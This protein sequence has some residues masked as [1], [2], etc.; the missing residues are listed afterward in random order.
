MALSSLVALAAAGCTVE[1][2]NNNAH[3]VTV[4]VRSAGGVPGAAGN[5]TLPGNGGRRSE[6]CKVNAPNSTWQTYFAVKGWDSCGFDACPPPLVNTGTCKHYPY[7]MGQGV[8]PSNGKWYGSVGF[9]WDG[10][11]QG[12]VGDMSKVGYGIGLQ[13]TAYGSKSVDDSCSPSGCNPDKPNYGKPNSGVEECDTD[14]PIVVTITP[15]ATVQGC[16][17]CSDCPQC[18]GKNCCGPSS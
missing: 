11:G 18:H 4:C 1:Y 6:P 13:C 9:N 14:K 5:F 10:D 8:S 15:A 16:I 17:P 3:A 12:Y 2:V 7:S